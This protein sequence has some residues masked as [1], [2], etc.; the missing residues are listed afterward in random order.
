MTHHVK[1]IFS[2]V[3]IIYT[4]FLDSDALTCG[5]ISL[6]FFPHWLGTA[7]MAAIAAIRHVFHF[8]PLLFCS[9]QK[10]VR[11]DEES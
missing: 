5:I 2:T 1:V 6:T 10:Y 11:K 8:Y 3:L 4:F 9:G 7:S